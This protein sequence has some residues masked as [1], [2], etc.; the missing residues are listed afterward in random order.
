M[1]TLEQKDEPFDRE[2]FKI[3]FFA[4]ILSLNVFKSPDLPQESRDS[5]KRD[6]VKSQLLKEFELI[7]EAKEQWKLINKARK[8]AA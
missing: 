3:Y 6:D 4:T 2:K 1:T 8:S 5:L 7:K